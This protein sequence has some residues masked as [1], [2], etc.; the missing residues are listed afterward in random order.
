MET[1]L[2]DELHRTFELATLRQK[3]NKVS[4]PEDWQK[5]NN[6]MTHYANEKK[7]QTQNYYAEYDSRVSKV[8][9]KLIDEAAGKDKKLTLKW[10]GHD[11]FDKDRLTRQ[12]NRLV[13]HD[14]HRRLKQLEENEIKELKELTSQI[15]QRD[16]VIEVSQD[17]NQTVDRRD[18]QERRI[19][20][21]R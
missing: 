15:E 1:S 7:K 16:A 18:G 19:T 20:R 21:K 10:F 17:F 11:P 5:V 6:I 4:K 12:A 8:M 2:N 13:Q 3:A 9:Q 14:H